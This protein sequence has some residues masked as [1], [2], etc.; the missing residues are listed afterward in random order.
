VP[1]GTLIFSLPHGRR[2]VIANVRYQPPATHPQID[3]AKH[4]Q[5]HR[6]AREVLAIDA[7]GRTFVLKDVAGTTGRRDDA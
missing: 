7:D 3:Q 5:L 1:R 2:T 6:R 4:G